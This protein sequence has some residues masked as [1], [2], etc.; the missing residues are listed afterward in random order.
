MQ[1]V[2]DYEK[3][4]KATTSSS[5][6]ARQL[7]AQLIPRFFKFFPGL[8]DPA[9]D[10]HLDLCEAEELGVSLPPYS[11]LS[12]IFYVSIYIVVRICYTAKDGGFMSMRVIAH[13]QEH[14]LDND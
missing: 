9:V 4:I 2:E 5:I 12:S 6:K 13:L 3:I 8:S 14:A 10:A 11:S 7:A 1:N